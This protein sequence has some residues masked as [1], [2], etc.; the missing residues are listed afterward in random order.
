MS[1]SSYM[2]STSQP[3]GVR[4]RQAFETSSLEH[5]SCIPFFSVGSTVAISR[6]TSSP[7]SSSSPS[8]S[9]RRPR[10]WR[11]AHR[12][13]KPSRTAHPVHR[14]AIIRAIEP[15]RTIH[16]VHR[17]S[18]KPSCTAHHVH[19]G[20][21]IRAAKPISHHPSST[22]CSI[23]R[24]HHAHHAPSSHAS[25]TNPT[26]TPAH[27]PASPRLRPPL[28][29][30]G[31][32]GLRPLSRRSPATRASR[33]FPPLAARAADRLSS[34]AASAA[35]HTGGALPRHACHQP[36]PSGLGRTAFTQP[37]ARVTA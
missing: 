13:I 12:F 8:S 33:L 31:C 27:H 9:P 16:H 26:I 22:T 28:T 17:V 25:L 20:A 3:A 36:P 7:P 30:S 6:P 14:G 37:A 11:V 19:R 34:A 18:I 2:L 21:V 4:A 29:H 35:S 5:P 15:S 24:G 23:H 1:D 10:R 32:Q